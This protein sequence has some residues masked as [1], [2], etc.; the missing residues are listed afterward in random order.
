MYRVCMYATHLT[1]SNERRDGLRREM[2]RD[3]IETRWD[4][5]RWG[6]DDDTCMYARTGAL[7]L[8]GWHGMAYSTVHV[9]INL[10][11]LYSTRLYSTRLDST[12][13]GRGRQTDHT[14]LGWCLRGTYIYTLLY[15]SRC[16]YWTLIIYMYIPYHTLVC[17]GICV[18]K[19]IQIIC[20]SCSI[21][22]AV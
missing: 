17:I 10:R 8:G 12:A 21:A 18:H 6:Q 16:Q 13:E 9:G 4:E 15:L 22:A 20:A 14:G 1:S 5:M 19:Q 2:R 11:L 3:E 7:S